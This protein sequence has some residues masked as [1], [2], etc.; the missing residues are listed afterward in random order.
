M[1]NKTIKKY[2]RLDYLAD[3][4]EDEDILDIIIGAVIED[5]EE[6]IPRFDKENITY[7]QKIIIFNSVQELYD[8]RTLYQE[9]GT[10]M[11]DSIRSMLL[12]EIY[13]GK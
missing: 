13:K 7:R 4:I 11:R 2:I 5:L 3:E 10:V 6:S 8:N 1:D 9:K 12:K